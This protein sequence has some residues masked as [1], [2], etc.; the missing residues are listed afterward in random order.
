VLRHLA[1]PAAHNAVSRHVRDVVTADET[2]V[3]VMQPSL[4]SFIGLWW[5]APLVAPGGSP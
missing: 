1:H 3:A 4:P 5:N 2:I